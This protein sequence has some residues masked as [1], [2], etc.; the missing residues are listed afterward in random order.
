[1]ATFRKYQH[2]PKSQ[3]LQMIDFV[4]MDGNPG[5]LEPPSNVHSLTQAQE[6]LLVPD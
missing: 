6:V 5:K 3:H 1:M 4:G 2:N